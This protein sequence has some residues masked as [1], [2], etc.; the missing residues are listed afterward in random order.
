[1]G[2]AVLFF[3][4]VLFFLRNDIAFLAFVAVGREAGRWGQGGQVVSQH[5][6]GIIEHLS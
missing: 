2:H 5:P 4:V 1:M 6:N 3:D